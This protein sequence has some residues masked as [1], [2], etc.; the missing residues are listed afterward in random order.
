MADVVLT[1]GE[2]STITAVVQGIQRKTKRRRS[3]SRS[4][5]A[6][7]ATACLSMP[8]I[9]GALDETITITTAV[10]RI[11]MAMVLTTFVAM[12]I[13]SM[14][15]HYQTQAALGTVEEA[16]LAARAMAVDNTPDSTDDDQH[17]S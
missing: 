3:A 10:M 2:R 11:G 4:G 6:M 12:T 15:D 17:D 8:I 5:W 9:A 7:L 14:I 13:G 16:L 1:A